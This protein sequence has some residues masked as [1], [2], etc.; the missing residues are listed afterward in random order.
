MIGIIVALIQPSVIR[1][2]YQGDCM[3]IST[4][5]GKD[6]LGTKRSFDPVSDLFENIP[7]PPTSVNPLFW[8]AFHA[9]FNVSRNQVNSEN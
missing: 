5:S 2:E 4:K 7:P 8:M 9:E 3:S 1:P 6:S